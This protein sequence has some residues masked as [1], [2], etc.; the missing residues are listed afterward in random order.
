MSF[1]CPVCRGNSETWP[2]VC[3]EPT[4]RAIEACEMMATKVVA[5]IKLKRIVAPADVEAL[6]DHLSMYL[7][8]Q[9]L[10]IHDAIRASIGIVRTARK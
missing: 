7:R 2:C 5:K 1:E 9:G 6:E 4:R 8:V 10:E 3:D